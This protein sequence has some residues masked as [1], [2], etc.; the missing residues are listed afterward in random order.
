MK[1]GPGTRRFA[2]WGADRPADPVA[3]EIYRVHPLLDPL[4]PSHH[5]SEARRWLAA[6]RAIVCDPGEGPRLMHAFVSPVVGDGKARGE[7]VESY[8]QDADQYLDD[9]L[10]LASAADRERLRP[11]PETRR[12][13]DFSPLLRTMF[14]APQ[15]RTRYEAQRKF[16]LV[17]L[18]F[19]I[20]HCRSVRD[21]P[22]HRAMLEALLQRT[23]WSLETHTH[24]VLCP[25][26]DREGASPGAAGGWRFEVRRL[27]LPDGG[28]DIDV[29]RHDLRFKREPAPA[30]E[31]LGD[32]T[33]GESGT[34]SCW[35][36]SRRRS[37]SI[38]S[39][40]IRKGI[41]DPHLISD[42]LGATFVVGDRR[43]AYELERRLVLALGGP[44]RWRDRVD[45][46][47]G[48]RDRSRLDR[49][50]AT[51]FRVIKQVVDVLVED[52]TAGAPYLFPVE[53]QI[54]RFEDYL[55]TLGG[56]DR[57]GHDAYKRRQFATRLLP[58]L[59]PSSIFGADNESA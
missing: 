50:S 1:R 29:Y 55:L 32:G 47:S 25:P 57:A 12:L 37:G 34:S 38:L 9:L 13:V 35:P 44:F 49:S 48:E 6:Y 3:V 31:T 42:I 17:K 56:A 16:Y 5:P 21:G 8:F 33:A 43:Q 51:G 24:E 59:F 23:L 39:K 52:R 28:P 46:L 19:D 58:V 14:D 45:T 4:L 54:F 20:D 15:P 41:G 36:A 30:R 40:M 53:I 11:L 10:C 18:L 7:S 2:R 22:R 26:D 27:K